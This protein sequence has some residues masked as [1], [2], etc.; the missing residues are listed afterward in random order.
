MVLLSQSVCMFFSLLYGIG[1]YF[2]VFINTKYISIK[3]RLFNLLL[4]FIQMLILSLLYFY[5]IYIINGG[6]LHLYFLLLVILGL[7]LPHEIVKK[8]KTM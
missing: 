1:L 8:D 2:V 4:L 3:S 5:I 7:L 6:I